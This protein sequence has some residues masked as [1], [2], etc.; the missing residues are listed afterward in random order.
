MQGALFRITE[1]LN[2]ETAELQTMARVLNSGPCVT[3]CTSVNPSRNHL[4]LPRE[5][6]LC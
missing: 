1:N 5:R 4:C 6:L 3:A 2:V